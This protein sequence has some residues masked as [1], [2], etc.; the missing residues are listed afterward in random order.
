V[1]QIVYGMIMNQEFRIIILVVAAFG[2]G[3][4]VLAANPDFRITQNWA[5]NREYYPGIVDFPESTPASAMTGTPAAYTPHDGY[6]DMPEAPV[7]DGG[8]TLDSGIIPD[9]LSDGN[10]EF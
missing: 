10:I 4:I 2:I 3:L 9:D 1:S 7:P 6:T 5:S 8:D